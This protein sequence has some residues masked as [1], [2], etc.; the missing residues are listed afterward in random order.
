MEFLRSIQTNDINLIATRFGKSKADFILKPNSGKGRVDTTT[1]KGCNITVSGHKVEAKL[2]IKDKIESIQYMLDTKVTSTDQKILLEFSSPNTNKPQ[3]LGHVRNNLIGESL[4]RMYRSAGHTVESVNLVN[5]R[6]VHICKSMLAYKKWNGTQTYIDFCTELMGAVPIKG[7]HIIGSFYVMF[8]KMSETDTTLNEQASEMLRKWEAGDSETLALWK[9]LNNM[10]YEGF[11][12]TYDLYDISFDTWT[13][14]SKLYEYGKHIIDTDP[15]FVR[16]PIEEQKESDLRKFVML[17]N[18][19]T[20]PKSKDNKVT[21]LRS[22]GTSL[23]ITQDIGVLTERIE[24]TGSDKV[25][26]VVADEQNQHFKNLFGIVSNLERF[27]A[28]KST[29]SMPDLKHFAYGMVYLPDGRLKS[30]EGRTVD[31]DSLVSDLRDM[32]MIKNTE[33]WADISEDERFHRAHNIALTAIKFQ[34]LSVNPTKKITFDPDSSI[35]IHGKTGP[36][37]IYTYAR[38]CSIFREVGGRSSCGEAFH[39]KLS[40][41]LENL[42]VNDLLF[43]LYSTQNNCRS[44]DPSPAVVCNNLYFLCKSINKFYKEHHI[45][46]LEDRK[47]TSDRL[48][49]LRMAHRAIQYMSDLIGLKMLERM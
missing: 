14:E 9:Q 1:I 44:S 47:L 36:Y 25:I 37:I 26:Y 48:M 15:L 3:H 2:S 4:K 16:L 6:G 24:K 8:S 12:E 45:K 32:L 39:D 42:I 46:G 35:D 7:D 27:K 49:V 40:E 30:R 10:V 29:G 34:V 13:Y 43:S 41:P 31:A 22:D 20:A 11:R 28:L 18:I 38:I 21:V 19:G 23:Y 33:S 5:D 17:S